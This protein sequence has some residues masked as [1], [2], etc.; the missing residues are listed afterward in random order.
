MRRNF[1]KKSAG[2]FKKSSGRKR[3]NQFFN[4]EDNVIDYKRPNTLS[5]FLT[6]HGKIVPRRVS[7][8][9]RQH[10]NRLVKA[11]KRARHLGLLPYT[12]QHFISGS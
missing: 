10:Q 4:E 8:L 5:R 1:K 12:Q 7:G 3:L 6:E 2:K 9:S 11:I